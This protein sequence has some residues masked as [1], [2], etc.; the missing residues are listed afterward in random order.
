[1]LIH[2]SPTHAAYNILQALGG[3]TNIKKYL[4]KYLITVT[5]QGL[6]KLFILTKSDIEIVIHY[7]NGLYVVNLKFKNENKISEFTA[8]RDQL[9][10]I[11]TKETNINFNKTIARL[12]NSN[13]LTKIKENLLLS[14][15]K[16]RIK[17]NS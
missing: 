6:N 13:Y 11:L 4:N 10:N 2:V 15:V 3:K 17:S 8:S 7:S 14:N 9:P 1:M 5:T 16:K 12:I